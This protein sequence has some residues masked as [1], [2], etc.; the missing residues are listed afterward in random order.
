MKSHDLCAVSGQMIKF[1]LQEVM[2]NL[3]WAELKSN[4]LCKTRAISIVVSTNIRGKF[5]K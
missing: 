4:F 3:S 1:V 2:V 5:R